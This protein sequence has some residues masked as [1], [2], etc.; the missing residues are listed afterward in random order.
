MGCHKA[1]CSSGLEGSKASLRKAPFKAFKPMADLVKRKGK[2]WEGKRHSRE[3][4]V[5][6]KAQRQK[7]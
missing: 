7:G 5:C 2:R 4:P 6:A 3:R 1:G